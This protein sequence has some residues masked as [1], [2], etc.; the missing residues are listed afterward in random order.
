M[1]VRCAPSPG[2]GFQMEPDPLEARSGPIAPTFFPVCPP[3]PLLSLPAASL[4]P[5]RPFPGPGWSSPPRQGRG[6][7]ARGAARLA[8]AFLLQDRQGRGRSPNASSL[9]LCCLD[10]PKILGFIS[11]PGPVRVALL[12]A[13]KRWNLTWREPRLEE[14]LYPK[15]SQNLEALTCL[16]LGLAFHGYFVTYPV[17]AIPLRKP[18]SF[19]TMFARFSSLD[20]HLTALYKG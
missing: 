15:V 5:P 4:Q 16:Y 6:S 14:M 18:K 2:L 1:G 8:P 7:P 20:T 11:H 3:A 10:T 19:P 13:L 9:F 17:E 12:C